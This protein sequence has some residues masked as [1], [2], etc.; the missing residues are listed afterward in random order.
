MR[1]AVTPASDAP[2][3][4]IAL[5][6]EAAEVIGALTADAQLAAAVLAQPMLGRPGVTPESLERLLGP[7]AARVAIDLQRL[8]E[9]GL[10]RDWAPERGL[11]AQQAETVRKMLLAVVGD[12]R[13]VLARL[14]EALVRLRH[15]RDLEIPERERLA[16]EV[17]AIFCA[18]GQPAGH[19]A[20]EMGA[21]GPGLPVPAAGGIQTPGRR[22]Q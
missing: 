8:G 21:G 10:S 6:T 11:D 19:L 13:L 9:I 4:A 22:A 17:R 14:A 7:G 16:T 3:S 15:A 18:P 20:T 2:E 12:Q 1:A 5:A